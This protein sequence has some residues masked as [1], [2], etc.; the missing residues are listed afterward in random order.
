MKHSNNI[1]T[2]TPNQK[3]ELYDNIANNVLENESPSIN[4][5]STHKVDF[6]TELHDG[7]KLHVNGA[8]IAM[9]D[10]EDEIY[11]FCMDVDA[12]GE[13]GDVYRFQFD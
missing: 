11:H 3:D 5:W 1:M 13:D 6:D 12:T 2:L 8:V 9:Y 4:T 10:T 7:M